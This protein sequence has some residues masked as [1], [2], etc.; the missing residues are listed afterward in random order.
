MTQLAHCQMSGCNNAIV[1]IIAFIIDLLP[2][3][4]ETW[5]GWQDVASWPVQN[6]PSLIPRAPQIAA[7]RPAGSSMAC[8]LQAPAYVQCVRRTILRCREFTLFSKPLADNAI[9]CQQ[10]SHP[11]M[12]RFQNSQLAST[13]PGNLDDAVKVGE[14]RKEKAE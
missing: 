8:F 14:A 1:Q 6:A 7:S 3:P 4:P 10:R 11:S 2:K 13:V 5:P 12:V 9:S